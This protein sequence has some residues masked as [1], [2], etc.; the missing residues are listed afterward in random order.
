MK[1]SFVISGSPLKIIL[2]LH[3]SY[4][5]RRTS[6]SSYF[7]LFSFKST[8]GAGGDFSLL[9]YDCISLLNKNKRERKN[10]II[11]TLFASIYFKEIPLSSFS[12]MCLISSYL[13][14]FGVNSSF[15]KET[16]LRDFFSSSSWFYLIF[17]I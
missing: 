17:L 16:F 11:F 14:S 3:S 9:T 4:K 2:F 7:F 5:K 10:N 13:I 12:K 8:T 6:Y 15:I 1:L